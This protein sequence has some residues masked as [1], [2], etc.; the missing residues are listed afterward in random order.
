MYKISDKVERK[1]IDIQPVDEFEILTDDG[2]K[3][4]KN[5]MK[6]IEYEVWHLV[7]ENGD[8][9]RCADTHIVFRE[10][11]SEVFV[12]DLNVGDAVITK[13]GVSRVV[14][15]CPT[16]IFEHMY[17]I[18]VD[19][20]DH[21]FYTNN[22][23]SHNSTTTAAYLLWVAIFNEAKEIA[24]LAN[25]LEQ[26]MEVMW[27]IGQMYVELPFWLQ[28]GCEYFNKG[29]MAFE[30]KSK[31]FGSASS[32]DA[33]RGRSLSIMYWD[34]AAVTQKDYEF[35]ESVYPVISAGETTKI[36]ITSTPKGT[37]GV[38][39]NLYTG[40]ESGRNEYKNICV[41]WNRVPGRDEKW[42]E[43][44]IKQIGETSFRQEFD[45]SFIRKFW[46]TYSIKYTREI[47][48]Y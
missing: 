24:V 30:N 4:I 25:K 37:R 47:R 20:E 42:K 19:S 8:F 16:G 29:S 3:D 27:R 31:I 34:E 6:T 45:C 14:E 13:S 23:L 41:P 35:Y 46:Y 44:T 40:A 26:S 48:I 17:D 12:C 11:L 32:P 22:V 21:R 28:Q 1:F 18:E 43:S 38:F 10:D 15:V 9:L 5:I 36:F 7:L 39:Y 2:W 33:I